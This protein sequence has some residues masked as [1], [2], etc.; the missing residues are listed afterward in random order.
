MS[1]KGFQ[2][3]VLTL[4]GLGMAV[5]FAAASFASSAQQQVAA[6]CGKGSSQGQRGRG[7]RPE[8]PRTSPANNYGFSEA[9]PFGEWT[10]RV[11]ID[12][13]QS[14]DPY[15]PVV[16][17]GVRSY[18]GKGAW[19]RQ[20]MIESVTLKNRTP[21]MVT[22]VR[23][24]WIILSDESRRARKNKEAAMVRG[25]SELLKPEWRSGSPF[26]KMGSLFIDFVKEARSLIKDGSL[27]GNLYLRLRVSEA[28]FS[29]GSVW[30]E[31][32]RLA[33][34]SRFADARSISAQLQAPDCQTQEVCFFLENGQ[35]ECRFDELST[36][37]CRRENCSPDDPQACFC[38]LHNCPDCR[39]QDQDGVF[40]CEGDCDDTDPDR[41]PENWENL[42][43]N[44][45]DGKDNDCDFEEDC[46]DVLCLEHP[47]CNGGCSYFSCDCPSNGNQ[48]ECC[49]YLAGWIWDG[50]SCACTQ[51][52]NNDGSPVVVDV[53]GDGFDLTSFSAGVDF[54][55]N[56]DGV[57]EHLSWTSAGSDDAWLVMD[58]NGNGTIDNG[59]E[60]F[61]NFTAQ[62]PS[63]SPN[64]FA[65]LA[66]FDRAS[67]GGNDDKLIDGRDS[68]FGRLL[69]W[70]DK[71]HNGI[72]EPAELH[73]LW[74]LGL[75]NVELEYKTAKRVDE[76]GNQ[77][78][79]RAKVKD[80][81]GAD[82]GHWAW[83]VFLK[84]AP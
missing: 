50:V 5:L 37:Y 73:T 8:D 1:R 12:P 15:V 43:N 51:P 49:C 61:G 23:L 42:G 3:I 72:S 22:G 79:Y 29:D 30:R 84:L 18:A 36:Q 58:R 2:T 83:D 66:E 38:N 27:S 67:R 70:Q 55:L 6:S 33:L 54:D 31:D 52:V 26:K 40:D 21:R 10:A 17:S 48:G 13:T 60:L 82:V 34:R 63:D 80:V 71:N 9:T 39:D 68:A 47:S 62:V 46:V 78:R 65:A 20:L 41:Y 45:S 69:L 75:T 19:G 11:D 25:E 76:H 57:K 4:L 64:G 77:F 35:G 53:E 7:K 74:E 14:P 16:V 56:S 59:R 28:R 44:C 81:R 24:G 32:D